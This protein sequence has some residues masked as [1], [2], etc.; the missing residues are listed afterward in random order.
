MTEEM[1]LHL[2]ACVTVVT[3]I[4][5]IPMNGFCV[6]IQIVLRSEEPVAD[7]TLPLCFVKMLILIVQDSPI[8]CGKVLL[9]GRAKPAIQWYR[10]FI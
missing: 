8:M 4:I 5:E 3:N 9:A 7:V 6:F 10:Y 1:P 2:K